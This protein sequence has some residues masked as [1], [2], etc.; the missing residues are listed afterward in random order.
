MI[1]DAG[2][3]ETE[4]RLRPVGLTPWVFSSS[5]GQPDAGID[6]HHQAG[7][8]RGNPKFLVLQLHACRSS[9][10]RSFQG[11]ANVRRG[12]PPELFTNRYPRHGARSEPVVELVQWSCDERG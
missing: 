7:M 9:T 11:I 8:N 4:R 3:C 1:I 5:Y 10:W 2:S 12:G 6:E